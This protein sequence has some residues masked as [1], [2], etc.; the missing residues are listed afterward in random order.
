MM[1]SNFLVDHARLFAHGMLSPAHAQP[2]FHV[3]EIYG[4]VGVKL[5]KVSLSNLNRSWLHLYQ[6]T[7]HAF[8]VDMRCNK[9]A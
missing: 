3:C 1:E 7:F 6:Q 8:E 9:K 2:T 4:R 5:R